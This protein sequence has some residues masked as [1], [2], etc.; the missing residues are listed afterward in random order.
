MDTITSSD[1]IRRRWLDNT[2]LGVNASLN[3]RSEKGELVLGGG[4]NRYEGDHFGEVIWARFAG[5]SDIRDR[6]YDNVG[7][8]RDAHGYAKYEHEVSKKWSVFGDVQYRQV[9]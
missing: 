1:L 8:K 5:N 6:Y 7:I 2:L 4:I 3:K 9:P